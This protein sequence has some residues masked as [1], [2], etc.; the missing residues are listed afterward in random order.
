MLMKRLL[1]MIMIGSQIISL[2]EKVFGQNKAESIVANQIKCSVTVEGDSWSR[3]KPAYAL[4]QLENVS[5]KDI[6]FW[7]GYY[8]YF[9]SLASSGYGR[10][11]DGYWSPAGVV[12]KDGQLVLV[13]HDLSKTLPPG[14]TSGRFPNEAVSLKK[15]ESKQIK[16][17]L[18]RLLWQDG[19][20]SY[21]PD[22]EFFDVIPKGRYWL[23]LE[24]VV[25]K[26]KRDSNRVEVLI[27]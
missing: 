22:G 4:I 25:N 23:E 5:G 24:M 19:I 7:A 14:R 18:T 2:P 8:F 27:E 17:D 15:G 13:A 26:Q 9:N 12:T 20:S 11:G 6:K 10:R 1:L 3:G 16:V 21:W